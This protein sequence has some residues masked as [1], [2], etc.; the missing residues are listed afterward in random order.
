MTY[1]EVVNVLYELWRAKAIKIDFKAEQ[2]RLLAAILRLK[3]DE[4]AEE[5][6]EFGDPDFSYLEPVGD[7]ETGPDT[8]TRLKPLVPE[9]TIKPEGTGGGGTGGGIVPR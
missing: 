8:G 6:P 5:R 2:D 9:P 4:S 7:E 3:E 1:G